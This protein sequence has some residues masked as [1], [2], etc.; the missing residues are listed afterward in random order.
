MLQFLDIF[1][2]NAKSVY[3]SEEKMESIEASIEVAAAS[4]V[5]GDITDKEA[6]ATLLTNALTRIDKH[7]VVSVH[8]SFDSEQEIATE[9]YW[10]RL[11][12]KN[13][14]F[15]S[16][17]ILE[18]NI[19]FLSLTGFDKVD[20]KSVKRAKVAMA[21]MSDVDSLIIDLRE[22]G[23][24]SPDMVS[25]LAGYFFEN[26]I[27]LSSIYERA[28]DTT[29]EFASEPASKDLR[30]PQMPLYLLTSS[31]TF[32][33]AEA[34]VYDLQHYERAIVVGE[35]TGGGA[36]PIRTYFYEEGFAVAIPYAKAIN[37]VTGSNW[38]GIGVKPNVEVL[39][40]NAFKKAYCF[41][42][43]D[44][45]GSSPKAPSSLDAQKQID[46]LDCG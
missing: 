29:I 28:S 40:E 39:A 7:F 31:D 3:V 19:G 20:T 41:A 23:G 24:G 11:R 16:V 18:G 17:Q 12:R 22:N 46:S 34:F 10:H 9:S 42:L 45:A 8:Q 32:S 14:G 37:P 13:S 15:Q 25:V 33:A 2:E 4:I 26:E 27:K 38:E 30:R 6:L 43:E 36:N 1:T 5:T 44:Q 21:F 35:R